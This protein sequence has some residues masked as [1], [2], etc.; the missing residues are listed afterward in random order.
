MMVHPQGASKHAC[1]LLAVTC[2]KISEDQ[3]KKDAAEDEP[4]YPFPELAS[5]GRLEVQYWI[6]GCNFLLLISE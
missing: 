4:R 2:G 5:S 1:S 3:L 6:F